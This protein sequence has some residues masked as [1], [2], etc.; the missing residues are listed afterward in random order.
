ME[1]RV[2]QHQPDFRGVAVHDLLHVG[3][4]GPAGLATGIEKFGDGDGPTERAKNNRMRA[5]EPASLKIGDRGADHSGWAG[6]DPGTGGKKD[7]SD[8]CDR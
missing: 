4:E 5:H 1:R 7:D 6:I 2:S 3:M 8:R